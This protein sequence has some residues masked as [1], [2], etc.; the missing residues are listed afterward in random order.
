METIIPIFKGLLGKM[1]SAT[2]GNSNQKYDD[3][4]KTH[5]GIKAS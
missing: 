3:Y 5:S 4:I 2:C 1:V